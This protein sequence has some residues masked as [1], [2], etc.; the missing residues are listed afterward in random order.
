M[1]DIFTE[2]TTIGYGSRVI[3]SFKAVIIGF[4]LLV[5]A[6]YLL[7]DNEGKPDLSKIARTAISI[8]AGQINSGAKLNEKLVSVTGDAH[9]EQMI[10]DDMFLS[11]GKF[12]AVNRIVQMYS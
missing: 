6:V 2:V 11:P 4:I 5:V 1:P 12:I 9:S 3:N 10:G 7:Y 8:N